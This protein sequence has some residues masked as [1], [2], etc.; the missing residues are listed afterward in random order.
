MRMLKVLRGMRIKYEFDSN[1]K[2]INGEFIDKVDA[3]T[4]SEGSFDSII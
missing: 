2:N 1:R 4:P 3:K